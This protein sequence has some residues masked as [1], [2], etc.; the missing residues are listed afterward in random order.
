[1]NANLV[2]IAATVTQMVQT[3]VNAS[4]IKAGPGQAGQAFEDRF[5]NE[6]N[7][8][9]TAGA[10]AAGSVTSVQAQAR[11]QQLASRVAQATETMEETTGAQFLDK[12]K[13]ALLDISKGQLG[14]MTLDAEGLDALKDL[15]LKAGFDFEQV[16]AVIAELKESSE[17]E[18]LRLD[19]IFDALSELEVEVDDNADAEV[20]YLETSALPYV[21]MMFKGL[22]VSD[23]DITAAMGE[24]DHGGKGISLDVI[25]ETLDA[26]AS[27]SGTSLTVD[28]SED[29][30]KAMMARLNLP[31]QKDSQESVT[32]HDLIQ[33][34]EDYKAE[35][36]AGLATDGPLSDVSSSVADPAGFESVKSLL[37]SFFQ[38]LSL[39][40][41]TQSMSFSSQQIKDQFVNDML[42][43]GSH[44]T[45]QKGVFAGNDAQINKAIKEIAV[46]LSGKGS[47]E[48][49][50]QDRSLGAAGKELKGEFTKNDSIFQGSTG[51]R[52][53]NLGASTN[54]SGPKASAPTLP[55]YVTNQVGRGIVRAVNQGETSLKLQL[56]PPDLG[57]LTMTIDHQST[58]LKVNIVAEN[59]AARD[60][61]ASNVNELK[62]AL[63]SAGISLERFDVDMNSNFKQSMAN[64][65]NPFGQSGRRNGN[66]QG[67]GSDSQGDEA[68]N[69]SPLSAENLVAD[70]SY[71]FVA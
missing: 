48:A 63:N 19:D 16:N 40:S 14:N 55:A 45:G 13:Q 11:V 30:F 6:I 50:E 58:G 69:E 56:N 68:G 1:M 41:K 53:N 67:A 65:G 12:M 27:E 32:I 39:A 64:A 15:L 70:G 7:R 2:D 4:A 9:D 29:S 46:L 35:K 57:R 66:R 59:H 10:I 8:L 5:Q 49:L 17:T 54:A 26:L 36:Q 43:P 44:E 20:V 60:I 37:N 62:S 51:N 23:A 38:S 24:A 28:D 34:F 33:A 71:H 22:G 31:V 52:G 3:G 42:I 25:V 61:L 18:T 47:G 21:K